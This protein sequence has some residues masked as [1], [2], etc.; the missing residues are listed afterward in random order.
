M[1]IGAIEVATTFFS[2]V[3]VKRFGDDPRLLALYLLIG[4]NATLEGFYRLEL[5]LISAH[6]GWPDDRVRA[7][8]GVLG[9]YDFARYD[10]GASVVF[11]VKRLK[12]VKHRNGNIRKGG[13]RALA[14]VRDA[15]D[16]FWAHLTAADKYQPAYASEIREFYGL[17]TSEPSSE[18]PSS[19][20]QPSSEKPMVGVGVGVVAYKDEIEDVFAH[21]QTALDHPRSK[22]GPKVAAYIRA[23]LKQ[24][25][26]VED[27]KLAIDGCAASDWHMGQ[28]PNHR[29]YDS[30]ELIMREDKIDGFISMAGTRKPEATAG[31]LGIS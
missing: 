5:E 7:A 20:E 30:L 21:W 10:Y 26:S 4:P 3:K 2:D 27:C 15:P 17:T 12:Y 11:V 24:G 18:K 13:V 8:M 1:T 25:Y 9:S 6:L 22:L 29:R 28:N 23:R 16:L 19:P 31:N 14:Q